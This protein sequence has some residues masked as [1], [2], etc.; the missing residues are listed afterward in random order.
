MR[1][2]QG[3]SGPPPGSGI[4]HNFRAAA[5]PFRVTR[6]TGPE[7]GAKQARAL[8]AEA[9]QAVL[10]TVSDPRALRMLAAHWAHEP[11]SGRNMPGNNFGGIKATAAA[12]FARLKTVEGYGATR[13]EVSARFRVYENARAGAHDYVRLLAE[14]Y[15]AALAAAS[16]GNVREFAH[17]LA[18]GGY[19]SAD[20]QSYRR[21]LERH[22]HELQAGEEASAGAAGPTA[23]AEGA[24]SGK[25][26]EVALG[27][28]ELALQGVLHAF[29]RALDA[30]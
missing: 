17:A 22:F 23:P 14:R 16:A 10:G 13:R 6:T 24:G 3:L 2:E 27:F 1:V 18:A 15:P 7:V 11:D 26:L 20:P 19:F 8:L 25:P 12:P 4:S 29:D 30:P 28:R 5:S 21:A 9:W